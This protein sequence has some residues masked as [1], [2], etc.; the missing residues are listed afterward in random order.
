[1]AT[2]EAN[3]RLSRFMAYEDSYRDLQHA[4]ALGNE[5]RD[6]LDRYQNLYNAL[7][8]YQRSLQQGLDRGVGGLKIVTGN[9]HVLQR[10]IDR[11][12]EGLKIVPVEISDGI[13]QSQT[14]LTKREHDEV[15]SFM[16]MKDY[17]ESG[18]PG[19][20][21]FWGNLNWEEQS[22]QDDASETTPRGKWYVRV[23]IPIDNKSFPQI[24]ADVRLD[25][26]DVVSTNRRISRLNISV[27]DTEVPVLELSRAQEVHSA[28][29]WRGKMYQELVWSL[30]GA[31]NPLRLTPE[32][33]GNRG[34]A[35]PYICKFY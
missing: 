24:N 7:P 22:S 18:I 8:W 34:K 33:I 30:R 4:E 31:K 27:N 12:G 1:M 6:Q 11:V 9:N 5:S 19:N 35:V 15:E 17:V 3:T 13:A 14:D 26:L 20:H 10:E 2:T 25:E 28:L 23:H 16:K 29:Q 32:I 21:V